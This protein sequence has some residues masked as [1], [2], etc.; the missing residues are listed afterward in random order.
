MTKSVFTSAL[1][2]A[3]TIITASCGSDSPAG[4]APTAED[5]RVVMKINDRE[6][7]YQEFRYYFLNNK[8]DSYDDTS[9]LT[10][11]A[12]SN[13]IKL[14]EANAKKHAALVIMADEY[15]AQL[16]KDQK[17]KVNEY[18]DNYRTGNFSDNE[19][20]RLALESQ[21]MTDNLFR[22]LSGETMLAENVI[23][24]MKENGK[25]ATDEESVNK[26]LSDDRLICIKEIFVSYDSE[27]D[28]EQA[29]REAE[30]AHAKLMNGEKFE[31]LMPK[32]SDYN[33]QSLPPEHGYYTT[34]HDAIEEVWEIAINLAIGE[35]SRV[36]ESPYG[37][38]I[39]LRCEKDEEYMMENKKEIFE[40]FAR[41]LFWEEF[42]AL[43]D[44]LTVEYT[45]YGKSLD[46]ANIK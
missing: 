18:V 42:Y 41:E 1:L 2:L 3:V 14:T 11:E 25:I 46:F 29:A 17:K 23:E 31:E 44:S 30:E 7:Q 20:Y 6:V 32:Y 16:T 13:L 24:K 4:F 8:R 38:H 45:E 21:Y 35:Y 33:T 15:D 27:A 43:M 22:E 5:K 39:I 9:T 10:D 37:F 26:S 28:K 40:I 34:E 19:A 12:I 36:V